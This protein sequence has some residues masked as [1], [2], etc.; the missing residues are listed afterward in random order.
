MSSNP[1][2]LPALPYDDWE[3][4]KAT[5]HMATQIMGKIK[6]ARHPK[7]SH[8]WH[9]TL[10]V[11][12]RGISTRTIPVPGGS[13]EIELDVHDLR[14][15][16]TSSDG[17]QAGFDL[18]GLSIADV[19]GQAMEALENLGYGTAILARPYD[20]PSSDIP[21]AE[22]EQHRTWDHKAIVAWWRTMMFVDEVF[23]TFAGHSFARTS[24]VQL[25]WH[26]FDMAVTRF[27]GRR[28]PSFGEGDRRSDVEAYSHEVISFGYWPGDP[29]VRFPAFYSYTAPEPDGL[30][31]HP[32]VPSSAWWQE[33]PTSHM[34]LLR[35]DD[36]RASDDPK[37]ALLSFLESAYAAGCASIEVD[38]C[39]ALNTEPLWDQLDGRFPLT[40][41]KEAR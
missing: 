7:Q 29:E 39:E 32:L 34:A 23:T 40:R 37:E 13:F 16:V 18:A 3:E 22:D 8:W 25:F 27:T 14:W 36:V 20:N 5:L 1:L 10:R 4:T 15:N 38:D 31:S 11:T 33:L 24:P 2:A 35:Y 26:S 17:R 9:A 28:S 41:N 21:F 6:L 30:T 12:P 19:Y